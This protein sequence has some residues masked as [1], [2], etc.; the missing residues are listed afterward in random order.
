LMEL[1]MILM[2]NSMFLEEMT[3]LWQHSSKECP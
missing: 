2:L 3:W 1:C